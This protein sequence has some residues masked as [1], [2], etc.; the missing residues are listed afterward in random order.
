MIKLSIY[1]IVAICLVIVGI[2]MFIIRQIDQFRSKKSVNK[3]IEKLKSNPAY[4]KEV[5]EDL[6]WLIKSVYYEDND[7]YREVDNIK[8]DEEIGNN[9][10]LFKQSLFDNK[11]LLITSYTDNDFDLTVSGNMG[12]VKKEYLYNYI[13][14]IDSAN[15]KIMVFSDTFSDRDEKHYKKNFADFILDKIILKKI[16]PKDNDLEIERDGLIGRS[17]ASIFNNGI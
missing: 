12:N 11:Y 13:L 4:S 3:L 1:V 5:S 15:K 8:I 9:K 2:F 14:Q 7:I 16:H 6:I 17:V 10:I